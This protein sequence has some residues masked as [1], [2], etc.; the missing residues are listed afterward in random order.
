[1]KTAAVVLLGATLRFVPIWF[2]LPCAD[3]RPDEAVAIGRALGILD[4]DLNPHFFHWPSLTFYL[5][6]GGFAIASRIE[7]ALG[8][9]PVLT[10]N[11]QY[12]IARAIVAS[13][14]TLTIVVLFAMTRRIA[15]NMTALA[16]AFF[17]AVATL[18][19][20]D[21]HF[22]MT[23][24]LMTLFIT[25]ALACLL[26]AVDEASAAGA[27]AAGAAR[28]FAAA[29]L[30][31]GLATSTKYSAAAMAAAM[32][33]VQ[34]RLLVQCGTPW[35]WRVWLPSAAFAGSAVL[36]FVAATPYALLD[37]RS[38][39]AGFAFDITHLSGG[40]GADV[41]MGWTYHLLRSLP[42]GVSLPIL[43]AAIGGVVQAARR[44]PRAALVTGAFCAALYVAI[45]GGRTAFF[46][47]VLPLVPPICLFAA[48]G[49]T[50]AAE[51]LARR[52]RFS[53]LVIA[54]SI[55]IV[56]GAPALA[57]SIT[58]DAALARTDTRVLASDWLAAHTRPDEVLY[59]GGGLFAR[60]CVVGV[61]V[62]RWSAETFD[63]SSNTFR[64]A[65]GRLPDWLVIPESPLAMYTTV[66]P[67][68]L[69]LAADRYA[70]ATRV[71]GTRK[72]PDRGVYDPQ[73]AFFLPIAGFDAVV[74]P[75]PTLLIYRRLD[76]PKG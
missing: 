16:A 24:V 5:F 43:A 74:R 34:L 4:G 54:A 35:R 6:A 64:D 11:A 60:A 7:R 50:T 39:V 1:L 44:Y 12:L 61:Q 20:R 26:R 37:A 42:N 68:L 10:P 57:T 48:V 9:G 41:G 71:T 51:W 14:G 59:D 3:A 49:V 29:G 47:Y 58:L 67:G 40:H 17:L 15:G 52:M 45:G 76:A 22:A 30:L 56:I 66:A 62:H 23:D 38:F 8:L 19:V 53:P 32:A 75:G 70:L 36:G 18:H 72:T 73:D 46:R 33:A 13:A 2:G 28:W 21:S 25:A 69:R 55:S 63:P 31:C 27:P 65:H